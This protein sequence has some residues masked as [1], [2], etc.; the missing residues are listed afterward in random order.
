MAPFTIELDTEGDLVFGEGASPM[1]T[2]ILED[3]GN[4]GACDR[5]LDA[6]A[7]IRAG[8]RAVFHGS[9]DAVHLT[10]T[11]QRASATIA[12]KL[13][14]NDPVPF[15]LDELEDGVR[16]TRDVLATRPEEP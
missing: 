11:P 1:L 2:L 15:T 14:R 10:I 4:L 16:R 13:T 12:A 6:L 9:Y 8:T 5:V 7:E 3:V